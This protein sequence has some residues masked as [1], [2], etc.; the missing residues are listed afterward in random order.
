VDLTNCPTEKW[1]GKGILNKM[2]IPESLG[3]GKFEQLLSSEVELFVH[4]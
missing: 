3:S 2:K 4:S 1:R